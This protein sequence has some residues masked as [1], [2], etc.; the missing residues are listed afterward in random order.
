MKLKLRKIDVIIVI[1]LII[2][3]GYV[4]IKVGYIPDPLSEKKPEITFI[5]DDEGHTLTVK[6]VSKNVLWKDIEIEGECDNSSLGK[7]VLVGDMITDCTGAIT[8]TYKPTNTHLWTFNFKQKEVLPDS[9]LAG[10]ERAV[11]PE[12]EGPHYDDLLVSREWWYY[13]AVFDSGLPGW[14]LSVSFNHMSRTDLFVEKPDIL[15]VT[16]HGPNG[17][18]YGG[19]IDRER[20][21]LGIFKEPSLQAKSSSK[22]FKVTFEESYAEGKA[23]SWHVHIEGEDIDSKHN[24]VIDIL[25]F[26]PN[27]PVWTFSNTPLEKSNGD[28]ASYI[29]TGCTVEGTIKID[30][31]TYNVKGIGHHDHTWVSGIII[32]SLIRGWDWCHMTLENGWNI[33][34]SNYYLTPQLRSTLTSKINPLASVIITTDKG[35]KI[36]RLENV[37][38]E[39]V[40]SDKALLFLNIPIEI[41][42]TGTTGSSQLL[43]QTYNIKLDLDI[44]ADNTYERVWKRLANVGMKIGRSTISGEISWSDQGEKHIVELE[45]IGTIWNMRH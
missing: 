10:F 13:T 9:F 29:F 16:L 37:D 25:Y 4:F 20:P 44:K 3:S 33:Y 30:T 42:I 35:Q 28:I 11:S 2:M 34:Y 32:K 12:D 41:K 43:L 24:L 7:E 36:T 22:G 8:F 40:E 45:G 18:E 19:I 23:P 5:Q 15:V 1:A 39:I 21:L 26:A 6:Y 38:I 14:T 17:E 27:S 31:I